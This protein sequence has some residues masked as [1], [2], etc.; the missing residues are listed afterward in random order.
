MFS[1]KSFVL[2]PLEYTIQKRAVG[3]TALELTIIATTYDKRVSA[4][5]VFLHVVAK[6]PEAHAQE[7]GRLDLHAAGTLQ[8]LGDVV[9]LDLL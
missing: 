8:R 9:A 2:V 4:Q 6:R 1:I 5:V 3:V 7:I